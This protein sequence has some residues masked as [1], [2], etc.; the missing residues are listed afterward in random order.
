MT[1][2]KKRELPALPGS[3]SFGCASENSNLPLKKSTRLAEQAVTQTSGDLDGV[4]WLFLRERPCEF[5]IFLDGT[6]VFGGVLVFFDGKPQGNPLLP[7]LLGTGLSQDAPISL[8]R[9]EILGGERLNLTA[10]GLDL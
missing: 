1:S 5:V 10:I 9:S 3:G 8:Q 7:F 6:Q 4:L 2:I